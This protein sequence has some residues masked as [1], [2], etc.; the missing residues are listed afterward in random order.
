[1]YFVI[2]AALSINAN[3]KRSVRGVKATMNLDVATFMA[4]G[5]DVVT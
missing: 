3:T 2:S 1:M 4:S 5:R